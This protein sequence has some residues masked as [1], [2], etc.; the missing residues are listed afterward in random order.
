[1]GTVRSAL[2][3]VEHHGLKTSCRLFLWK[4]DLRMSLNNKWQLYNQEPL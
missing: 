2:Q 3:L 1:M 4:K